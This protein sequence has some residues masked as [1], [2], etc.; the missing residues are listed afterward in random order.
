MKF[1]RQT[2]ARNYRGGIMKDIRYGFRIREEDKD[3]DEALSKLTKNERSDYIRNAIRFYIY[4]K[5]KLDNIDRKLDVILKRFENKS[6]SLSV[7]PS[8]SQSINTQDTEK[9]NKSEE[10][11]V[12]SVMDLL[13]M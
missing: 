11:L 6:D 9:L 7:S 2:F 4:Y 5:D 12:D 1:I 10:L 13:S 3:I 8:V